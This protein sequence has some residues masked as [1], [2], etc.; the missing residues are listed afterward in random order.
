V[1]EKV[2][3]INTKDFLGYIR[4]NLNI[5]KVIAPTIHKDKNRL[6]EVNPDNLNLINLFGYRT[7]EPIKS[8]FFRLIEK[9]SKYFGSDEHPKGQILTVVG[10]RA[11]DI[12]ALEVLDKVFTEGEFKD[13]FYAEA[14]KDIT[15]ISADCTDCGNTC[16]CTLVK[17][18][19]YPSKN[20]DLNLTPIK[21]GFVV[22]VG[23]EKGGR[24]IEENKNVFV[25]AYAYHIEG[26]EKTRKK[27][28][29]LLKEKNRQYPLRS[30]ISD[31]HKAN[32][33]NK[34]WKMLTKDCVECSAC[35]FIC[36][37]C[38]C[39][40]LI[41]QEKDKNSERFKV[42]DACLKTGYARVAGGANSRP[43]LYERLQ[44]RYH[45]KFDYSFDRL[46]RYTC[47]GC[48]RC[49][50]GCAGNIDMRKIF[51]EL[52]KQAPLTARLE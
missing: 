10:A 17:G 41:D 46:G 8:Y 19:A 5:S 32:I 9:V 35:N 2:Y 30:E 48:G 3:F 11:C 22:G 25:E 51:V 39:F 12:E 6:I 47:V 29:S 20:F 52:E 14:R 38:S 49:I 1:K 40:L 24:I 44:N 50:D 21:E 16:F 37:S 36:P 31:T 7:V 23:S 42:W 43:K 45:C 15:I 28:A 4:K 18:K 33:N 26:R 34:I 13:P 27:V